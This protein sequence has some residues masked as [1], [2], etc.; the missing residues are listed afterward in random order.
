MIPIYLGIS[1]ASG[2]LY[3]V[4]GSDLPLANKTKYRDAGCPL[5]GCILVGMNNYPMSGMAWLGLILSFGLSW[6]AMTT[7]FK[8][9]G[10]DAQWYNWLFVGLAFG[11]AFLP[12]TWTTGTWLP[13]ALRTFACAVLIM[14][15]SQLIGNAVIEEF[16]RGFI[17]AFTLLLFQSKG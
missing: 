13:F 12:W 5:L 10:T 15:W 2:V 1:I 7:Y 16:G 3:R 14:G 11:V 8:K 4:G 9:K 17:Y 6:G